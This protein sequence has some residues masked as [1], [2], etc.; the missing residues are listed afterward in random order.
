MLDTR[1]IGYWSD[2]VLYVGDMETNDIA[3]GHDGS[4]FSYWARV[5]GVFTVKRFTWNIDN[6]R[7]QIRFTCRL[8]GTW[9]VHLGHI[10][11]YVTGERGCSSAWA[12][13]Y[14]ISRADDALGNPTTV[15]TLDR[16]IGVG[17]Q[18]FA[19]LRDTIEDPTRKR[20]KRRPP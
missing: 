12:A 2:E 7:L 6:Q 9:T 20:H 16:R 3:F 1:L 17:G 10:R 11:H 4:G 5:G 18:R 15:L 14:R 8:S 13:P 19:Y